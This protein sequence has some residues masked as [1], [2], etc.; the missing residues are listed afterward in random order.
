MRDIV[1][2]QTL[3]LPEKHV[4]QVAEKSGKRVQPHTVKLYEGLRNHCK[5]VEPLTTV[6][7]L[8]KISTLLL[9]ARLWL[10]NTE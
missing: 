1:Y 10:R 9:N 5:I 7:K 6:T 8:L 3:L 2:T 4:G